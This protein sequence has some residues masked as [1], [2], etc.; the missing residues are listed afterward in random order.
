MLRITAHQRTAIRATER[1]LAQIPFATAQA[2][3]RTALDFQQEERSHL[4][5]AFEVR[6]KQWVERNVKIGRGDFAR[7]DKLKA[8][9]RME[10]PGTGR[11]DILAK[12]EEGGEKVP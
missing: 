5:K 8:T 1:V 3:N 6:R 9:V 10:A 2:I 11:S 7:K 4:L 12:F